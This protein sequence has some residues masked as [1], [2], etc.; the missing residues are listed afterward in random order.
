M[1]DEWEHGIKPAFDSRE[2]TWTLN[3]PFECLDI[4]SLKAGAPLPKITLTASD[5]RAAFDPVVGKIR[6]MV[7]EQVNAV[8]TVK[9]KDPKYVTLVG[10]FG[11]CRFLFTNLKEHLAGDIEVLQSR[12]SGP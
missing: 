2:K 8:R 11:R 9:G 12:G 5:V 7:D 3:L 6:A 1:H 4:K 10:G